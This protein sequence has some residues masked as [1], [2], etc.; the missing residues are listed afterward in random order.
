VQIEYIY[1]LCGTKLVNIS[2]QANKNSKKMSLESK[3]NDLG[4]AP[5]LKNMEIGDKTAFPIEM[6][7]SV[8]N[9][10]S[11]IKIIEKKVFKTKQLNAVRLIQV[12]RVA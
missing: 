2:I 9:T 6:M 7:N 8:K 1:Y 5:T 4:I 3:K 12:T 10:A 11:N